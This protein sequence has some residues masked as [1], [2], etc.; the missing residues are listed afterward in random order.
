MNP[1]SLA[2]IRHQFTKLFN[3]VGGP[4]TRSELKAL[5]DE[6]IEMVD[7]FADDMAAD[8]LRQLEQLDKLEK[9]INKFP[10]MILEEIEKALNTE[11][12]TNG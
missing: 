11:G 8:L 1:V 6:G 7:K 9:E 3:A 10:Q 5:C 12:A 4:H 2:E